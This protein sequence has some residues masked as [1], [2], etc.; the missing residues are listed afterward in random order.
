MLS[1]RDRVFLATFTTLLVALVCTVHA[2]IYMDRLP[3]RVPSHFDGS[4]NPNSWS[5][6]GTVL[7]VYMATVW[8]LVVIFLVVGWLI[9]ITPMEYVNLPNKEYWLAT[10]LR[11]TETYT[12]LF[13]VFQIWGASTNAFMLFVFQLMFSAAIN[14]E[15]LSNLFW[16]GFAVYMLAT[17][18]FSISLA[19]RFRRLPADAQ[20]VAAASLRSGQK[21]QLLI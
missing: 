13:T 10:P 17:A 18:A 2:L 4:G 19:L 15:A 9:T 21:Q 11:R 7:G 5:S 20:P 1:P 16:F 8:G 6:K 14:G 12:Y 3:S